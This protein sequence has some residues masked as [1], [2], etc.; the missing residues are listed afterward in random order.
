MEAGN[1]PLLLSQK[2]V[3]TC[4]FL[5]AAIALFGGAVQMYL[6]EP[7]TTA[8][9][10]NVHRFMA[11]IYFSCGMI[12][13]WTAITIR[14]QNTLV[15]LLAIAIFLGGT[16]RLVSM[17]IVGLPEPR[18]LWLGYLIPE[19]LLPVIIVLAQ[20]ATN[21]KPGLKSEDHA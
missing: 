11:G 3:R 7:E 21:R 9:L 5:A 8:R 18:G 20:M 12:V 19:L 4:L 15:F 17:S 1:F 13:L 6:G 14:K 16:G 2:I 10:D